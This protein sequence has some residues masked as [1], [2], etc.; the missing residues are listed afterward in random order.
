MMVHSILEGKFTEMCAEVIAA[1]MSVKRFIE[2]YHIEGF[3]KVVAAQNPLD[4]LVHTYVCT[5]CPW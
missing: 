1:K 4:G 2:D 3:V 5:T